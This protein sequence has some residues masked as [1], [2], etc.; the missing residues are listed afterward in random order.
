MAI[1]SAPCCARLTANFHTLFSRQRAFRAPEMCFGAARSFLINFAVMKVSRRNSTP[2]F[3]AWMHGILLHDSWFARNF[4]YLLFHSIFVSLI[5]LMNIRMI[6]THQT[7]REFFL[8]RKIRSVS[9]R[10]STTT[11]SYLC[12]VNSHWPKAR[13]CQAYYEAVL[14]MLR[15]IKSRESRVL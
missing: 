6:P 3:H 1:D 12:A 14:F 5:S 13:C 11:H 15:L 10:D 8:D 4:C 2:S 9:L 7:K